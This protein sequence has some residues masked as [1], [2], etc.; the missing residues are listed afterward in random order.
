[1]Y[2]HHS[3]RLGLNETRGRFIVRMLVYGS[4]GV[5]LNENLFLFRIR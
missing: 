1:M 4:R 2:G 5:N 3:K